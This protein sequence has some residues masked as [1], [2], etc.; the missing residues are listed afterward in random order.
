ML[1]FSRLSKK[2]IPFT[3]LGLD[4]YVISYSETPLVK[5][6]IVE[7]KIRRFDFPNFYSLKLIYGIIINYN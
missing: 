5:L 6:N 3:V 7:Y 1:I 4:C 2:K